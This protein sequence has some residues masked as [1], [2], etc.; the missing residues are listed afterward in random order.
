LATTHPALE[1]DDPRKQSML[2][3]IWAEPRG[4][5]GW[6]KCVHH[7]TIGRR[8]FFTA[9]IF[10]LLGGALAVVMRLQLLRPENQLVNPDLYNQIFTMHG[11]TM[12]FLFAVP[13]MFEAFSVYLVPLMVGARNIAF[14]RLNAFS[15]YVYVFGG[16]LLYAGFFMNTGAD[17][18]WFAYVPLSGP[19]FTPGK[20][21][22]FWAQM[23]TFTEL[24]ALAVAV[25]IV[26]TVFKLRAPGMSLNR[27]PIFV[28]NQMV[29]AFM[30]I[31]AMPAVM[32]SSTMLIMD[33]LVAT[34]FFNPAE[35][36][37][38]ILYQ[39]LFWFFGHPEVYIIFLPGTAIVSTIIP[40]FA[41]RRIIGYTALVL[42]I[43]ST[44]FLSF[45]VW[46]HHMFATGLPALGMSFFSAA[47][48]MVVIPTAIQYFLWLATLWFGK[49]DLKVPL[50]WVLGF[51]GVFLIGGLTGVMLAIIPLDLQV[52][53]TYFVIAHFHYV[54]IGGA[55]FP[56]F[57]GLYFWWPKITGKLLSERLGRWQFWLFFFGFN[58]TFFPMHMLGLRGM[59][60]RVYTYQ[61]ESGWQYLNQLATFGATLMVISV[62]LFLWNVWRTHR[63][64]TRAPDN[65]W[66]ASGLEWATTSPPPHYNFLNL[67]TVNGREALWDAAPDQ[68]I[69]TG[70]H[71]DAREV[72]VTKAIDADPDHLAE[73]PGPSIWPFL[74]AVAVTILFVGSMFTPWAV[75]WG[76]IPV[77]ITLIGWFW[78]KK[79]E[80]ERRKV[81]ERWD[82]S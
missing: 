27:M 24:S 9:L 59:T 4:F 80:A 35:G 44:G 65:P 57:A 76:S 79:D 42:A 26:V 32:L 66:N 29:V 17:A 52:H 58:L 21:S 6:F 34:H 12:M 51:I 77:T 53:D 49:L 45:G 19:E 81:R 62:A 28:W 23:I 50:L 22:D 46:V 56:M 7:T 20:R 25:E 55:V 48:L 74:A 3:E 15:Y 37:D 2:A 75:V 11:T 73:M 54:L 14:P 82:R 72:L 71:H 13:M 36:G 30:V 10:L 64:G 68:P 33:R 39:H 31:F 5:V 63:F 70:L 8:Y 67:P 78:P 47:T 40:A 1:S 38:A 18:G 61:P 16:L 60:R 69:V 41:R 43:V